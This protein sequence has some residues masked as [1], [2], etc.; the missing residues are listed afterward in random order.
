MAT[1][2]TDIEP[3]DRKET[4]GVIVRDKLRAALMAGRF[5]PGEKLTIR[6]VATALDV[7]LTPAREALYNLVAEGVLDFSSAGTALVPNLAAGQIAEIG[8]IRSA[9]EGLAAT[10]A[11]AKIDTAT[12]RQVETIQKQMIDADA[13]KDYPRLIRLNWQFHFLI[14]E[15][16]QMPALT[17]LIENCWLRTGSY[18]NVMYPTYSDAVAGLQQHDLIVEAL[19]NRDTAGLRDAIQTDIRLATGYLMTH[20]AP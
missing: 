12:I 20:S 8:K 16:A 1:A 14:Y 4:L 11:S 9:L 13:D 17:R 2:L 6:A 5:R 10:E 15:A 18:L 3:V 7:S 19:R